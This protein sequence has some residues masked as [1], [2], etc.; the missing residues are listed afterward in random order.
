MNQ[1]S[2]AG[3]LAYLNGRFLPFAEARLPVFDLA[4]VQ[5]ASVTERL[6]TI[7]HEPYQVAE[8]L[9]RLEHSL[10]R[11]GWGL[12]LDTGPLE[13]VVAQVARENVRGLPEDA[14]LAII[15]F[16]SAGQ[17]LTDAN[18]LVERS[19]PTVCVTTAPLPL[20]SW[21]PAYSEGVRLQIPET[22]QPPPQTL[23][24]RIKMRSRL[25]WHLAAQEV[26]QTDPSAHALLL[27]LDGNVTETASGNLFAVS[28]GQLVTPRAD[29][30]LNG[31]AQRHVIQLARASGWQVEQRDLS[32]A[33]LAE[34]EEAFLTSSTYCLLPVG[35]LNGRRLGTRIPGP[36]TKMLLDLWSEEIGLD[37]EGQTLTAASRESAR[38]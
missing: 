19:R 16:V 33:E 30:T 23:D 6:R 22:R 18:G 11:V 20:A 12:P 21:A 1:P 4:I 10:D 8:H 38:G 36:I 32:P 13:D 5:G 25:H 28:Q 37:L 27:D 17:A 29:R 34:A 14:D 35:S 2:A 7:R 26:R 31:I 3:P 24:P 9:A 15:I